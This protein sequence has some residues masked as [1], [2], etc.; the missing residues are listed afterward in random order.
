[1]RTRG[2]SSSV[3]P[4]FVFLVLAVVAASLVLASCGDDSGGLLQRMFD[5]DERAAKNAPPST[6]ED[7]KAAIRQYQDEVD[8]T[9]SAMEKM[10][11]YW[12]LLA[13]RYLDAGLYGDAYDA[14][15]KALR[16]YTDSAGLYYIAA[17]SA[18]Q[19]S[20]TSAAMVSGAQATRDEW[21]VTAVASYKRA[22][23]IEPAHSKSLYGLAVV[24]TFELEDHAAALE[25]ITR[26]LAKNT[27]DVDAMFVRARALY[28]TGRLQEAAD[29]Y[30]MIITITVIDDKKRMAEDNKKQ[31]LDELVD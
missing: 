20:K 9:V 12:R 15:R 1:M 2:L 28:G 14:A 13:T 25:P 18:A 6:V 31:V 11:G 3:K 23:E 10:A 16:H 27:R 26:Y 30:D 19:L 4:G 21:L 7:L 22:L 24:Y 29:Q 8:R 5:L 17:V